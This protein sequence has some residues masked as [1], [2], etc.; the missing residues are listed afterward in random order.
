MDQE[1]IQLFSQP[2]NVQVR[3][4]WQCSGCGHV[5]ELKT[6]AS[7]LQNLLIPEAP[8]GWHC[9][10]EINLGYGVSWYC[11][12]HK[13]TVVNVSMQPWNHLHSWQAES[14]YCVGCGM[15]KWGSWPIGG[16][17]PAGNVIPPP[18]P[19]MP[20]IL[21]YCPICGVVNHMHKQEKCK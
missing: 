5:E 18:I 14:P 20:S 2:S 10:G 19:S 9:V 21:P 11:P 16:I 6:G 3:Y 4:E 13:I 17:D 7:K 8:E 1:M 15:T 12:K